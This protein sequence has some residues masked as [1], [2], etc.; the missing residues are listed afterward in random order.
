M[1]RLMVW[2]VSAMLAI[3]TWK[4]HSL[5]RQQKWLRDQHRYGRGLLKGWQER[6]K[7]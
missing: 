2:A 5:N 6:C 7:S 4:I 1:G 3:I